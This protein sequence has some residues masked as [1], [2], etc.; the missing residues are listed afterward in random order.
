M[1]LKN[2]FSKIHF[3]SQDD[4]VCLYSINNTA[5]SVCVINIKN[6]FFYESPTVKHMFSVSTMDLYRGI[7]S[8]SIADKIK[9][10]KEDNSLGIEIFGPNKSLKLNIPCEYVYHLDYIID[11][12]PSFTYLSKSVA[13]TINS[14]LLFDRLS[15]LKPLFDTIFF[16]WDQTRFYI[17][18][19]KDTIES[20]CCVPLLESTNTCPDD[21]KIDVEFLKD[22]AHFST[23]DP[24]KEVL[25]SYIP[26]D[27]ILI[28]KFDLKKD[29]NV[30]FFHCLE[31]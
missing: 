5:S 3:V 24:K 19:K 17:F 31:S 7:K 15:L 8:S 21:I 12:I 28:F 25:I 20:T 10:A 23:L 26:E 14:K 29:S 27:H 9:I 22:I 6:E 16:K 4:Q 1:H 11:P 13:V 18:A 30:V 2:L